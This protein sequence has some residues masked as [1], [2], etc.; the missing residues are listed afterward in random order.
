MELPKTDSNGRPT[1]FRARLTRE[2][3]YLNPSEIAGDA[4]IDEDEL[5]ITV[6][7]E[8]GSAKQK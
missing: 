8:A 7:I 3:R 4:M 1:S 6:T 2:G 5:Q